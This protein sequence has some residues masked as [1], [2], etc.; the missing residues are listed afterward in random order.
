MEDPPGLPRPCPRRY[1][2]DPVGAQH[3]DE[4]GF[5]ESVRLVAPG[6]S[7]RRIRREVQAPARQLRAGSL[8]N[9]SGPFLGAPFSRSHSA[10]LRSARQLFS[11]VGSGTHRSGPRRGENGHPGPGGDRAGLWSVAGLAEPFHAGGGG[12][13]RRHVGAAETSCAR[14]VHRPLHGTPHPAPRHR[15]LHGPR[16]RGQAAHCGAGDLFAPVAH[17][18]LHLRVLCFGGKSLSPGDPAVLRPAPG[19]LPRPRRGAGT[20]PRGRK[21]LPRGG[22][23]GSTARATCF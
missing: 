13:F 6:N 23:R 8:E 19:R 10:R 2:P 12:L 16:S 17:L 15:G 3:R 7:P 4:P 5:L 11:P 20:E 22:A 14:V 9:R 18:A 21:S 1:H